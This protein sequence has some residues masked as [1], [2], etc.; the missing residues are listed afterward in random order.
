M[1]FDEDPAAVGPLEP[2]Q[3]FDQRALAGPV[4]ANEPKHLAPV[5]V[6]VD[7]AQGHDRAKAL[8]DASPPAGSRRRRRGAI[9]GRAR[10]PIL[11][12]VG[13][14]LIVGSF[15]ARRLNCTLRP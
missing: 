9:V 6:H 10:E 13:A 12:K 15:V 8:G 5:E 3:D 4:V 2:A 14:V 7:A 1:A 11:G